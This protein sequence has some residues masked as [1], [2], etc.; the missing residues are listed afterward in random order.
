MRFV[1][2]FIF[3]GLLFYFIYVYFPDAFHTLA[4]WAEH[5]FLV[6]KQLYQAVADKVPH[7]TMQ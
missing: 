6:V 4:G 7:T 1:L 3:F 2:N 5:A